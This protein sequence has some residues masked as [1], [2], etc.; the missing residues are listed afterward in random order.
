LQLVLYLLLYFTRA[1]AS[2]IVLITLAQIN[3]PIAH[4]IFHLA[5]QIAIA[6]HQHVMATEMAAVVIKTTI[7]SI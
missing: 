2:K 6:I 3:R 1:Q 5:V 7:N 4:Q